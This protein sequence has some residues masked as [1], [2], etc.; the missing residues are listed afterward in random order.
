MCFISKILQF[1]LSFLKS[2]VCSE[3]FVIVGLV[4]FI[5]FTEEVGDHEHSNVHQW[6]DSIRHLIPV[7]L[8]DI[9]LQLLDVFL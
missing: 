2:I 9:F 7:I 4:P 8:E 3:F 5:L 1:P 6:C